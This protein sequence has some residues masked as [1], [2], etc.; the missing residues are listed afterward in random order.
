VQNRASVC[1]F[2]D[3]FDEMWDHW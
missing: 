3:N 1:L 2:V